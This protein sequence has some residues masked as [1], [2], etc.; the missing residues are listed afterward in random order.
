MANPVNGRVHLTATIKT[1]SDAAW[2]NART[3]LEES[4]KA[5][6]EGIEIRGVTIDNARLD[7]VQA[8]DIIGGAEPSD[9]EGDDNEEKGEEGAGDEEA[10]D[11]DEPEE[12]PKKSKKDKAAKGKKKGRK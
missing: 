11:N 6:L 10:P 3:A 9:A 4:V 7:F 1:G 8:T 2:K 12:K 5:A